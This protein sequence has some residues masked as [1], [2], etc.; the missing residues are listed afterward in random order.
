MQAVPP[1]EVTSDTAALTGA[2][3]GTFEPYF[4]SSSEAT[5]SANPFVSGAASAQFNAPVTAKP[6]DSG[7]AAVPATAKEAE[8]ARKERDLERRQAEL[9]R[10]EAQVHCLC[11]PCHF[12]FLGVLQDHREN[13]NIGAYI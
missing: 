12:S 10:R 3:G 6:G 1:G 7:G 13:V 8:L 5:R 11:M 2:M 4:D 9:Q